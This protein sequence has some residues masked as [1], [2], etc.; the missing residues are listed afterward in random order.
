[1]TTLLPKEVID[2]TLSGFA[3][4]SRPQVL[5]KIQNEL[6][7]KE[8]DPR[9]IER[10]IKADVSLSAA[11][12]KA[13][14]SPFFVTDNLEAFFLDALMVTTIGSSDHGTRRQGCR[15]MVKSYGCGA[16]RTTGRGCCRDLLAAD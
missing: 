14:N 15:R 4:P 12:L 9:H 11:V 1:M 16:V 5:E 3:I 10:L 8:P 6:M 7:K 13:V 2:K